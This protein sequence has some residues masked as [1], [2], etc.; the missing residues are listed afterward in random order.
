MF[1]IHVPI[2]LRVGQ[3]KSVSTKYSD[4]SCQ[5][6]LSKECIIPTYSITRGAWLSIIKSNHIQI[7]LIIL[8]FIIISF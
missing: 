1:K 3:S 4:Y 7:L 6:Q 8:G 5:E 2:D